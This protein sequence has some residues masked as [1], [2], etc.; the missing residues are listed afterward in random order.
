MQRVTATEMDT[1]VDAQK[2]K[3]G[4]RNKRQVRCIYCLRLAK[5][6]EAKR[7]WIDGHLRGYLHL[8]HMLLY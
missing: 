8:F 2:A 4:R 6:G 3:L 1:A 5:P 7:L